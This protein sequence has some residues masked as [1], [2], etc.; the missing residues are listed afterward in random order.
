MTGLCSSQCEPNWL[1]TVSGFQGSSCGGFPAYPAVLSAASHQTCV[2]RQ[3]DTLRTRLGAVN[4]F[5]E[6]FSPQAGR[7]TSE[8][9][10]G[11]HERLPE[12]AGRRQSGAASHVAATGWLWFRLPIPLSTHAP[13]SSSDVRR[14]GAVLYQRP[15]G[16]ARW[17]APALL[18][19]TRLERSGTAAS[20]RAAKQGRRRASLAAQST[21]IG[22]AKRRLPTCTSA[23]ATRARAHVYTRAS[24]ASPSSLTPP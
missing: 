17:R 9:D 14:C 7:L 21:A 23:P 19:Y 11:K 22:R 24:T 10:L 1:V 4:G 2:R 5:S 13:V 20:A 16:R 8:A 15:T 6:V 3:G 12:V 18:V